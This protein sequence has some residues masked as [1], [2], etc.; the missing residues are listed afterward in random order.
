MVSEWM[1]NG[2]ITQYLK[3]NDTADRLQLLRDATKGL[4]YMHNQGIA[5]GDLKGL[6][7]MVNNNGR[8]VLADFGLVNFAPDQ[9]TLLSS[10]MEAG[11]VRWMSPELLDPQKYGFPKIRPTKESDCYALGM[12]VY[13]ILSGSTPFGT[14]NSFAILRRVLEGERPERPKG[15]AAKL[16][17]GSIWSVVK[18]SWED[19][20]QDRASAR[21]V[22]RCLGGDPNAE[23]EADDLSD[24]AADDVDAAD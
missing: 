1:K 9:P 22:L 24:A 20:P 21:D 4:I 5:H 14:D 12:V 18:R 11:T 8:A 10:C 15:D 19:Q 13:E 16:F 23:G 7:I 2:T 17:T 3:E 6:N